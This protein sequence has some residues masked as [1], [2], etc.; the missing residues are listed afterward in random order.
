[1]ATVQYAWVFEAPKDLTQP[2]GVA[3]EIPSHGNS[4]TKVPSGESALSALAQAL[5]TTRSHLNDI[6]TRWKDFVGPEQDSSLGIVNKQ[7]P[8]VNGEEADAN[9]N[10][11]E[12]DEEEEEEQ[13]E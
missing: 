1:M 11:E 8:S 9:E 5:D 12:E 7:Y 2:S 13:E 6:V 10:E 3:Q 4:E